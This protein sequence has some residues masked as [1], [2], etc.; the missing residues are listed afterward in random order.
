MVWAE[1]WSEAVIVKA[2]K[3]RALYRRKWRMDQFLRDLVRFLDLGCLGE[4][5]F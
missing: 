3:D 5:G 4:N 2:A 1:G